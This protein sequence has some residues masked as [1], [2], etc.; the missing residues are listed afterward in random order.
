[1]IRSK[2]NRRFNRSH[3]LDVKLSARHR[4]EVRTRWLTTGL[5][6]AIG[7]VAVMALVWRGG[8]W[9]LEEYVYRNPAFAIK[10]I[11]VRTDGVIAST[12]ILR[13]G[14]GREG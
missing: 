7:V 3:V 2:K 6:V 12:E 14:G 4:R 10:A 13:W 9:F 11:E 5:G 1:V 8:V